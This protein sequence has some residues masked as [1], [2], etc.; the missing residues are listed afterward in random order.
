MIIVFIG[1]FLIVIGALTSAEKGTTKVGVGGLI[2]FIPFGYW[3]DQKMKWLVIGFVA[4]SMIL[5]FFLTF[6]LR[7][8]H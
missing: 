5:L 1:I 7:T 8:K 4:L 2:G 3:S 6:Y